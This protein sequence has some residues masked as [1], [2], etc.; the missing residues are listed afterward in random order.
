M[1]SGIGIGTAGFYYV[2]DIPVV[3]VYV[4]GE[5]CIRNIK[6]SLLWQLIV[7]FVNKDKS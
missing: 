4:D 1:S 3:E 6:R 7:K 5:D 2:D